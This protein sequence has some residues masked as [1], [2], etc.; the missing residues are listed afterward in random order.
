MGISKVEDTPPEGVRTS[1]LNPYEPGGK[2]VRAMTN[3][4]SGWRARSVR[5]RSGL[6]ICRSQ[7][8]TVPP[9]CPRPSKTP[10]CRAGREE[11]GAGEIQAVGIMAGGDAL[12]EQARQAAGGRNDEDHHRQD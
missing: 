7:R 9:G 5:G 3:R 1:A 4:P 8:V 12:I 10:N 11:F 2:F 6:G